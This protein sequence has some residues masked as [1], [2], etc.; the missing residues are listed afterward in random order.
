MPSK[1]VEERATGQ[2][3][4]ILVSFAPFVDELHA[5]KVSLSSFN[6]LDNVTVNTHCPFM[7]A[8]YGIKA[9]TRHAHPL[10]EQITS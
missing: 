10:D 3:V 4:S 1:S 5:M 8:P 7:N 2:P 9:I 6:F